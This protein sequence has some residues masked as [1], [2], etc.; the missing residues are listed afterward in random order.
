MKSDALFTYIN[1]LIEKID[2]NI[3]YE[4]LK[5]SI[6]HT[7]SKHNE[8]WQVVFNRPNYLRIL[9]N[10]DSQYLQTEQSMFA[11]FHFE[12]NEFFIDIIPNPL[13]PGAALNP[14]TV[15]KRSSFTYKD[16]TNNPKNFTDCLILTISELMTSAHG[17]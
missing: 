16:I 7:F 14:D 6:V 3:D 5:Y 10:P 17:V 12:D 2:I 8:F 4:K 1:L 13:N 15:V 9:T 11:D